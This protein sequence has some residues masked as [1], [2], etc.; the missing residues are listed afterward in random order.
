MNSLSNFTHLSL[1]GSFFSKL[2]LLPRSAQ[3][4]LEAELALIL[5]NPAPTHQPARPD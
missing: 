2:K 3:A 1:A 5:I 4:Q